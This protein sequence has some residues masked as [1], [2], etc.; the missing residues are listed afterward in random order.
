MV[1]HCL[2][3]GYGFRLFILLLA[4]CLFT[5]HTIA[6][7]N[8]SSKKVTL[9]YNS[10]RLADLLIA[11]E[12]QTGLAFFYS[13]DA[14]NP[15]QIVKD[16]RLEHVTLTNAL[17]QILE[18]RGYQWEIR[19]KQ[20]L[21]FPANTNSTSGSNTIPDTLKRIPA[22]KGRV[23]SPAGE[24]LESATIV[25]GKGFVT[26]TD[27]QGWFVINDMDTAL[28]IRVS[29][30]GYLPQQIQLHGASV[31]N[32]I[33]QPAITELAAVPVNATGYQQLSPER[34]TG[35]FDQVSNALLNR[36]V[37]PTVVDRLE[38]V[39]SGVMFPNR[40]I[41][42]NSTESFI[43][44][45]G[46]STIMANTQPLIVVDNFPYTGNINQI[47]P[48][49]IDNI[50]ILKD[51]AA[52]SIWGAFSG[53][54]VIVIT[55]KKGKLRQPLKVEV[56]A[57]LTV[58]LKPNLFYNPAFLDSKDFINIEKYLFQQGFYDGALAD[59]YS[60]PVISPVVELLNKQRNG[61]ISAADA[62]AQI[63]QFEKYD[64]RKDA[65][66][67][68]YRPSFNQQYAIGLSGGSEKNTYQFSAGYDRN[69][70]DIVRDNY[71]RVTLGS[72]NTF[73]ILNRVELSSG[74]TFT[75]TNENGGGAL[76]NYTMLLPGGGKALYYPYARLADD[77]GQPLTVPKDYR[78]SFI[79]TLGNKDGLSDWTYTPLE[80]IK[81][82][83]D[84][85][86]TYH[87]RFNPGI[88]YTIID[89]LDIAFKYQFEKQIMSDNLLYDKDSYYARNMYNLFT[90]VDGAGT[91]THPF[92]AGGIMTNVENNITTHNFRG[93]LDLERI[94]AGK[95]E[96]TA[97][98]GVEQ[99]ETSVKSNSST[100]YGYSADP[101]SYTTALDY[102][103]WF[104]YYMNLGVGGSTIQTPNVKRITNN[105]FISYFFNAAYTYNR[106]YIVSASSRLDQSNLFGVN[107][108]RKGVPLWSAGIAWQVNQESFYQ[109]KW[110][111][112]LKLRATYGYNGN[113]DPSALAL[114]V[115]Q[116]LGLTN[117]AGLS[118]AGILSYPS[119]NLR[120]E[121]TAML[122]LGVDFATRDQVI[123]GSVEYYHKKGSDLIGSRIAALQTGMDLIRDNYAD[124][125]G[126]GVDINLISYNI[127][128]GFEWS[129]NFLFSY[130]AD[131]VTNY[132]APS[133]NNL[134]VPS[135]NGSSSIIVPVLDRPV[136]SLFSYRWGGLD[137][138][139][140]DPL[141]YV[142]GKISKDYSA[143]MA[144]SNPADM[145]YNGPARPTIFGALRNDFSYRALTLSVNFTYKAGYYFRR[146]GINYDALFNNWSGGHEEYARRW[147]HPGD[148][149]HTNVPSM[150]YPSN[151]NRDLFY[152][153]SAALAEKG[154]HIRLQDI[155]LSYSFKK[156][157]RTT[158]KEFEL[159]GYANNLGI[160]WRANRAGLD[161]DYIL[162]YP[163]PRTFSFGCKTIF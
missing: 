44:I 39:A 104:P 36:R 56:N 40:E 111:P 13:T 161:P 100:F 112:F 105:E 32:V 102:T 48:N 10:I 42:G 134:I 138:N 144:S 109:S 31:I 147:Q 37:G 97:I 96:I 80:D 86:E 157:K 82:I 35:S 130:N 45:R 152:A 67:Y 62:A 11:I 159:Y 46:R 94:F 106:R 24:G 52:S 140:G 132:M 71:S 28:D 154:D 139:T 54:G 23:T 85:T 72:Y 15:D 21:V 143:I 128:R 113:L 65:S 87:I 12:K 123:S 60:Y 155:R 121:K 148:E 5:I 151:Y 158:I 142:N 26:K 83:N 58:G 20:I 77:K 122:N 14:V 129:T 116:Y 88:K 120:W 55:T 34:A 22:L 38:G 16:I 49:D 114:L 126:R 141:G 95:H 17:Q 78:Y 43:S 149:L 68:L 92:P 18:R 131:R 81:H 79:S 29:Y 7:E 137:H 64:L 76:S 146:Q 124:M 110:L 61:E 99:R 117:E 9:R 108:N 89:G 127:R 115:I 153:N 53:N 136:Y 41:P 98:A 135:A 93:Q 74:L 91:I 30:T 103:T 73:R 57:N 162:G 160:L 4:P 27:K 119:A 50:T 133:P 75:L 3:P 63:S 47:N 150:V 25:T 107:I 101:L 2:R 145:V 84:P 90:Q 70:G 1:T 59:T 66:K 163:M 33:L 156:L 118:Q 125:V 69:K 19:S 6:Q 51:A 8:P